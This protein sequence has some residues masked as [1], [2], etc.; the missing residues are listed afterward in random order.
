MASDKRPRLPRGGKLS[1]TDGR[2]PRHLAIEMPPHA[3]P[4]FCLGM[5]LK[6]LRA[7]QS[8]EHG[9]TRRDTKLLYISSYDSPGLHT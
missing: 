8:A 5:G 9:A 1:G 4:Y 7:R 6:S 3:A 2:G